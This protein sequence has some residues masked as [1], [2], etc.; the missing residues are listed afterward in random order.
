M[1]H[2]NRPGRT[3][4]SGG[5]LILVKVGLGYTK[6]EELPQVELPLS[7][8]SIIV[9]LRG[10]RI[11]ARRIS[12]VYFSPALKPTEAQVR[13]LTDKGSRFWHEGAA[14]K[15]WHWW[16]REPYEPVA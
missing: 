2:T 3:Q 15:P 4:A 12:G 10:A 5:V 8:G 16:R 14:A 9:Y 1:T 13:P 6:A 7:G 11:P